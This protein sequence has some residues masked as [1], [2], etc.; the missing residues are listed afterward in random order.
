MSFNRDNVTW[1]R[2]DGTW[3]MGFWDF[4]PTSSWNDPDFDPEWDVEYTN[5]FNWIYEN[6]ATPEAAYDI[7]R[8]QNGNPGGTAIYESTPANAD[9]IARFES[10]L[11]RFKARHT[12]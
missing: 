1:Q 7:Y 6:A 10:A 4:Y 2:T 11:A 12:R 9:T 8:S 3:C 5:E